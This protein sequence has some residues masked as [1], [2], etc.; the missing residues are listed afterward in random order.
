MPQ[1]ALCCRLLTEFP[2]SSKLASMF[3]S[4][5]G[6]ARFC[7]RQKTGFHGPV[8]V[9]HVY[10]RGDEPRAVR[11]HEPVARV[12]A[13]GTVPGFDA[14]RPRAR[15][16]PSR[17]AR[18]HGF[19]PALSRPRPQPAPP[20]GKVAHPAENPVARH[21]RAG[22]GKLQRFRERVPDTRVVQAAL[23]APVRDARARHPLRV[24]FQLEVDVQRRVQEK[25]RE[26]PFRIQGRRGVV[27]MC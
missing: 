27:E 20:R 6:R 22:R 18:V 5:Q 13:G 4:L 26:N 1:S 8:A 19:R 7:L 17:A 16:V 14:D 25:N 9:F 3:L 11:V 23:I 12:L 21:Q 24:G 2:A 15:V 10:L